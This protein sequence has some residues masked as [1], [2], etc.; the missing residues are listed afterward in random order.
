MF[1]ELTRKITKKNGPKNTKKGVLFPLATKK[2]HHQK[3]FRLPISTPHAQLFFYFSTQTATIKTPNSTDIFKK[4]KVFFDILTVKIPLS[5][6]KIMIFGRLFHQKSSSANYGLYYT[7]I[8]NLSE[9]S[10]F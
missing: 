9:K 5:K 8:Q 3:L 1:I 10:S 6:T 4:A 7:I 2:V